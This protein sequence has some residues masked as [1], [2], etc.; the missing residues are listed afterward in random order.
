MLRHTH[1]KTKI[2]KFALIFFF[3]IMALGMVIALAPLPDFSSLE[4]QSNVLAQIGGESIT[5]Q[6][7]DKSVRNQ[8]QSATGRFVPQ[9]AAL[10]APQVLDN[11][12]LRRALALQAKK[13][14]LQVTDEEVMKA[15]QAIPS[16]YPNGK[17]VG[18]QQ[19]QLMTGVTVNEFLSEERQNLLV[20][21]VRSLVTDGLR[22]T[23]EEV[24]AQYVAANAKAKIDYVV[25]DPSQY[26]KAVE[27]TP[28]ALEDFYKKSPDRYRV[29]EQRRVRYVLIT[30]DRLRAEAKVTG[31]E[32]NQYYSQ[33]LSDYR[34]PDRVHLAR[35]LFKTAGKSPDEVAALSK[36]AVAV[37]AQI[38]SGKS[39]EDLA[40]QDSEDPNASK[41]GD[42]G[43]I[44]R[45]QMEQQL[46]TVAFSLAPGQMSG[47]VKTDYGLEI[48]KVLEKQTAH[49]QTFDEVKDQIQSVLEKQKLGDVQASFSE[50]LDQKLKA[51]PQHFAAIAKAAGLE[52]QETPPFRYRQVVPDFGNSQSFADLAFQLRPG[53]VGQPFSVPK[54]TAIIQLIESLPEHVM[55]LDQV[56]PYV[57]EDYRAAQSKVL[58]AQKAAEFAKKAASGDFKAAA[59]AMGLTEKESND[60]SQQDTVEGLGPGSAL[61][62]AFTL[63]PGKTSGV[64]PVGGNNAVFR[65][66]SHIPAN[67]AD[68]AAQKDQIAQQLLDQKQELA[69]ELYAKDLKQQLLKSG[70]L[71][72]NDAGLKQFLATY[73]NQGT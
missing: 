31:Q 59:R 49:L 67:E 29:A 61:A 35:I 71:K 45:G 60:F 19:F 14:G 40:K 5:T 3:G 17:F 63:D 9:Y 64:V 32:L 48:I 65:V 39:F 10:Y 69:F 68:F 54:G 52:T 50:N 36:K 53:E 27:V 21:K 41:G 46:E 51:D 2:Y 18:E 70:D 55:P 73:S 28:Q 25:F 16:L 6:Q 22:V 15:A 7:L 26:M 23:P 4:P 44:Q 72:V 33:H 56:R 11:L 8:L 66:V 57:E 43:W 37:L 1:T 20:Q 47:V 13:L 38:K 24:H 42:A 12:I 34:V 30:P 58:A 62:A